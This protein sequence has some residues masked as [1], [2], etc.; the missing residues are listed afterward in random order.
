MKTPFTL[1]R[2]APGCYQTTDG[3]YEIISFTRPEKDDYGPAGQ[4]VW[5]FRSLPY[6]DVA[7]SFDTKREAVQAMNAWAAR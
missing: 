4:P 3:K 1:K 6:G 2:L 7:E 5:Y